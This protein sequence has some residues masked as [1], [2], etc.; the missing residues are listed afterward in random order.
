MYGTFHHFRTFDE[1]ASA[2]KQFTSK[3]SS[4]SRSSSHTGHLRN[5]FIPSRGSKF[6]GNG[7]VVELTL[8]VMI[9]NDRRREVKYRQSQEVLVDIPENLVEDINIVA[10]HGLSSENTQSPGHIARMKI[11]C[12]SKA[13]RNLLLLAGNFKRTQRRETVVTGDGEEEV[14]SGD[15]EERKEREKR[16]KNELIILGECCSTPSEFFEDKR[17]LPFKYKIQKK[18]FQFSRD[19]M[20]R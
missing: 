7:A 16:D 9:N 15:G 1:V 17:S 8:R 6:Q 14:V 2:T 18:E 3:C 12:L 19:G 4:V 13:R 10:E 20:P 11:S 5:K